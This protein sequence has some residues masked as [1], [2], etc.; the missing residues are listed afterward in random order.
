MRQL[1]ELELERQAD[2]AV[3]RLDGE[4]DISNAKEVEAEIA[5]AVSN[6]AWAL[7]VDLSRVR[8]LDSAGVRLLV[9]LARRLRTRGQELRIAIPEGAPIKEVLVLSNLE[10][11]APL[12]ATVEEAVS[13]IGREVND[14]GG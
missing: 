13:E 10:E 9:G 14:H 8:Y 4:V 1:V 11:V 6:D 2:V 12:H 7:V 5:A 3:A